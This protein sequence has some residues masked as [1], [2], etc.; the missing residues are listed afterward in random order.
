MLKHLFVKDFVLI[1]ECRLDFEA[2]FSA[3]TGETGAG[4]S[5]LIDAMCLLAGER[6]SAS[7]IKQNA[8]KAI[9][10][11]TFWIRPDSPVAEVMKRAA[12]PVEE[13]AVYR[14]EI[15]RDGKSSVFINGRP[16]TLNL[17]K[18][19]VQHEIDIHSQH[20]TQYLLNKNSQLQL[21]DRMI[22]APELI[23]TVR[24]RYERYHAL[25]KEY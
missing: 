12:I 4:K 15:N 20:D 1:D 6:A 14:R 7:Y 18:E 16:A 21:V 25:K 24:Q 17:L 19:C 3:F 11:G 5:L 9:V 10:E 13:T 23:Q 22:L 2:G 8:A